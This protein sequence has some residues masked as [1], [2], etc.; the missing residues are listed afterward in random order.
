V[1]TYRCVVLRVRPSSRERSLTPMSCR[2]D[3]KEV[4]MA[5]AALERL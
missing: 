5:K 3:E 4:R 2:P 1:A